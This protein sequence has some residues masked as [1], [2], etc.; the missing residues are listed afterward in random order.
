MK[1]KKF[2]GMKVPEEVYNQLNDL[3]AKIIQGGTKNLPF[4][5]SDIK[6]MNWGTI[7]SL[8][9]KATEYLLKNEE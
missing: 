5:T 6:N 9:I 4:D 8:C 3:R 1:N 2:K 7:I